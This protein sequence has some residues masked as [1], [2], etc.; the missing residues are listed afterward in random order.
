MKFL[1]DQNI[2]CRILK[3]AV[4][5]I[6]QTQFLLTGNIQGQV[7]VVDV[8]KCMT[9]TKQIDLSDITEQLTYIRLNDANQTALIGQISKIAAN[10]SYFIVYDD[11]SKK[12]FLYDASGNF[13]RFLLGYGK[14]PFEYIGVNSI[15]INQNNDILVLI[16][17]AQI[18][19]INADNDRK[20]QFRAGGSS[21][22][23]KWLN[24]MIVIFRPYPHFITNKGFEISF[25]DKDG[26]VINQAMQNS[27][28]GISYDDWAPYYSCGRNKGELYYWNAYD[29]TVYTI[30]NDMKVLPRLAFKHSKQKYSNEDRKKG[31]RYDPLAGNYVQDSYRESGEMAFCSFAYGQKG[32]S[33]YINRLTG[34]GYNILYDYNA[35]HFRGFKNNINGGGEFWPSFG[36][37]NGDLFSYVDPD[38]LK[39]AFQKHQKAKIPVKYPAQ[40]DSL[41]KNVIDKITINDNPIL[42]K[43]KR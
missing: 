31:A 13:K 8:Y 16:N 3:I 29:D 43:L 37:E 19:V 42:I 17:S 7:A 27:I 14:G 1:F 32:A 2:S 33:I 39:E 6:V 34:E 22:I 38:R 35:D 40:Q 41:Q 36:T 10:D 11:Q 12:L 15:D 24:S 4:F 20:M 25:L 9:T 28:S 23:A 30:T 5:F 26:K 21:P 18:I